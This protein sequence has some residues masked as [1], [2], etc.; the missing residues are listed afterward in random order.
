MHGRVDHQNRHVR[1]GLTNTLFKMCK[2]F[3]A[4]SGNNWN[5]KI[6][7]MN[8]NVSLLSFA[9]VVMFNCHSQFRL[10]P[11]DSIRRD[12]INKLTQIDY[13]DMLKQLRIT[14]TRPGPSGNPQSPNAANT[15]ESKASPY[16]TLPNPL[17]LKDGR[18]VSEAKTWWVQ[19]RPQIMADFDREIYGQ[20]PANTPK[21][22][23]HVIKDTTELNGN[24]KVHTKK[25]IG[26][27]DNSSCPSIDVDIDLTVSTP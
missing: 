13:D 7:N 19:R 25:L 11:A 2:A 16:S 10:S 22:K 18:R 9:I 21:V 26:R 3:A 5:F 24:F 27:V 8:K 4:N 6:A 14:S 20:V 17:V 1:N 12:S 15:D 23:W